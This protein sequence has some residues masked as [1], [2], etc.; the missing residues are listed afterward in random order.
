MPH[1]GSLDRIAVGEYQT[2]KCDCV[3]NDES[4]CSPDGKFEVSAAGVGDKA[5]VEQ[6]N[7]DLS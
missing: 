5:S 4:D 2:D 1:P 3:H 7:G 6:Q